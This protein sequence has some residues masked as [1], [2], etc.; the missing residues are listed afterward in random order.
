[1]AASLSDE[2]ACV[3]RP[4]VDL[5]DLCTCLPDLKSLFGGLNWVSHVHHSDGPNA[6]DKL[7]EAGEVRRIDIPRTGEGVRSL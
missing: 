2:E 1:M 4:Q 3:G 7:Q 6:W 5:Q